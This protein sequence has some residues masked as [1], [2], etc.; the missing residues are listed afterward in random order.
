[1]LKRIYVWEFPV[2]LTHWVNFLAILILCLTGYYIGSPYLHAPAGEAFYMAIMRFIHF[3]TAYVFTA[4]FIVR[5][6]WGIA[7]NEYSHW[8][9]FYPFAGQR[10]KDL[11][12]CVQYYLFWRTECPPATGH[13]ASA[14]FSYLILFVLFAIEI[15]TGFAL[16]SQSHPRGFLWTLLGGWLLSF[17]SA[18]FLRLIH[19]LIMW[20]IIIF[21]IIH[22][23]I[24][25]LNDIAEKKFVMSSIFGGYKGVHED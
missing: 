3:V 14:A 13:S 22:I 4:S 5:I 1:M 11:I 20:A 6:Y 25:W 7:G 9:Q 8:R 18:P 23:Y 15:I 17:F 19:H 10:R 21:A 24:G 12:G 2:R 16:Y